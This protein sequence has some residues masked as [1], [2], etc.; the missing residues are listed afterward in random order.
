MQEPGSGNFKAEF[1]PK[2]A[3]E[4][5]MYISFRGNR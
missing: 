5:Y 3:G 2:L 4:H 1:Y